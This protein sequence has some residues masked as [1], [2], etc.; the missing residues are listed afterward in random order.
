MQTLFYNLLEVSIIVGI[1]IAVAALSLPLLGRHYGVKWRKLL[2][3][4][5]AVRLIIPFNIS[6]PNPP[7]Q[8][9]RTSK[10]VVHDGF[11][12]YLDETETVITDNSGTSSSPSA[13]PRKKDT[14]R[15]PL[16]LWIVILWALGAF[17]YLRNQYLNYRYFLKSC[18]DLD[19][20][21]TSEYTDVLKEV[22][23][24][25]GIRKPPVIYICNYVSTP[26]IIGYQKPRLLMPEKHYTMQEARLIFTHECTHYKG[27]DLWYKLLIILCTALHWFNPLVHYMKRLAFRDIELV[28][29]QNTC[30]AMNKQERYAYCNVIL[31]FAA[32]KNSREI[33]TSTCFLGS[34]EIMKQRITNVF[35]TAKRKVGL[36]PLSFIL[37]AMLVGGLLITCG[38]QIQKVLSPTA[39]VS[40]QPVSDTEPSE[41]VVFLAKTGDI[42]ELHIGETFTL[43]NYYI[44]NSTKA[45]TKL[46]IDEEQTLW[47][48]LSDSIGSGYGFSPPYQE[49]LQIAKHVI[50]V[51]HNGREQFLYLTAD[52]RL[53]D[54]PSSQPIGEDVAYARCGD[55]SIVVLKKDGS[56]WVKGTYENPSPVLPPAGAQYAPG[57]LDGTLSYPTLTKILDN[58]IYV[59]SGSN[60]AGA[61]TKKGE[62]YT[63]GDNLFG[64][65]GQGTGIPIMAKPQKAASNVKMVW[66][67]KLEL[68]TPWKEAVPIDTR[69][70]SSLDYNNTF[71]EKTNGEILVCGKDV[72]EEYHIPLQ[73]D[74]VSGRSEPT[75]FST[76]FSPCEIKSM[77]IE[78]GNAFFKQLSFGMTEAQV[79]QQLAEHDILYTVDTYGETD[80]PEHVDYHIKGYV[81]ITLRFNQYKQYAALIVGQGPAVDDDIRVNATTEALFSLYGPPLFRWSQS[82]SEFF[83]YKRDTYYRTF[84]TVNERIMYIIDSVTPYEQIFTDQI[85]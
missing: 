12:V 34:K 73:G 37:A 77:K 46:F 80:S 4:V 15:V 20:W 45:S 9:L 78:E 14:L 7:I 54:G 66:F 49:P 68:N 21:Y 27:K 38:E 71:I 24:S 23:A 63:W 84:L 40:V 41:K 48:T 25:L 44:T 19:E 6:L 42:G 47:L 56:V 53:F 61:I 30:L 3:F 29:D 17:I 72:S 79:Q 64:E 60:T 59:S 81:E 36:I 1:I 26:L 16:L 32:N 52:G 43:S 31:R 70:D 8:L 11:R 67:E 10:E 65:C 18:E 35:D 33:D 55:T 13:S 58:C 28:C 76:D 2:W 39:N 75:F 69:I 5:L 83:S 74:E 50:H 22:C 82:D 51:D 62:L 85:Q 57:D